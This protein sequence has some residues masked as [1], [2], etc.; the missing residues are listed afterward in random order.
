MRHQTTLRQV[1]THEKAAKPPM[2]ELLQTARFFYRTDFFLFLV[3]CFG[4]LEPGRVFLE[5]WHLRH[6]AYILSE[7]EAGRI[8]RLIINVPP[9]SLKS[10]LVTTA[11]PAWCLGRNP[12]KRFICVS[13]SE[14]LARLHGR[15]TRI[16]MEH[17][18]FRQSFPRTRLSSKRPRDTDFRTTRLG[19]PPRGRDR[20]RDHR[21]RGRHYHLRRSYEGTRCQFRSRAEACYR[22][23]RKRSSEPASTTS[24]TGAII[25]VMQRLHEGDLS[26]HLIGQGGWTVVSLPATAIEAATYQLSDDPTDLYHRPVGELLHE[27]REGSAELAEL[28]RSLGTYRYEAEYQLRPVPA[29]GLV[30]QRQWLRFYDEEPAQRDRTLVSWDT[31]STLEE[32]SDYSVGTVWRRVGQ[33]MYLIEVIRGRFETPQLQREMIEVAEYYKP[34]VFFDRERWGRT[35]I[36]PKHSAKTSYL[37]LPPSD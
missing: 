3:R 22:I 27:A 36:V 6:L 31:A 26:G 34:D 9:R 35:R 29:I 4:V 24:A 11:F 19:L 17:E 23:C 10:L 8:K 1:P 25:V 16:I 15:G 21:A 33:D 28:Q 7:V 14:D 32:R 18:F 30:V 13:Y 12:T 37:A 20:R 5:N 2:N